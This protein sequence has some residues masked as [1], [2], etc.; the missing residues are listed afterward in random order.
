MK[1]LCLVVWP[2]HP[3]EILRGESTL[4]VIG[5][6]NLSLTANQLFAWLML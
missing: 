1:P 3:L 5:D 2:D 4:P 6:L